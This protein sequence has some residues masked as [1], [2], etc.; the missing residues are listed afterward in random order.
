MANVGLSGGLTSSV[1]LED[2]ENERSVLVRMDELP[3]NVRLHD[4]LRNRAS[5]QALLWS[6]VRRKEMVLPVLQKPVHGPI[7]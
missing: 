1:S 2:L 6:G 3:R 5:L 4:S 7:L